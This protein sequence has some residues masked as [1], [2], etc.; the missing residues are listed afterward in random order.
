LPSV[1]LT[2]G[3]RRVSISPSQILESLTFL[4]IYI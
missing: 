4:C 1:L 2:F 3:E